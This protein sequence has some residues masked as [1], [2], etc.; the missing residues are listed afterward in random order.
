MN[1]TSR[2]DKPESAANQGRGV[3]KLGSRLPITEEIGK[4]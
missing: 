3:L 2:D 4:P 1:E